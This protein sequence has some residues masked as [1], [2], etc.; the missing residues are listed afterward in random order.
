V[1][2]GA[3]LVIYGL[4]VVSTVLHQQDTEAYRAGG[5][6][7]LEGRPLYAT[8]LQHPFPD[9]TLR[10][11]YI[12]PPAF[13]LLMVPLAVLPSSVAL[14]VWALVN[15]GALLA[16]A[17]LTIRALH[18]GR[19]ALAAMVAATATFYPLWI[20]A[21]QGQANLLILL[22]VC[23]GLVGLTQRQDRLAAAI[24]VAAALKLT[25]A[26]FLL[27]LLLE[28]RW[29]AAVWMAAAFLATTAAGAMV[30]FQDTL[31][32]FTRVLPALAHGTAYYANQSLGGFLARVGTANRY[33]DPWFLLP[34]VALMSLLG[35]LL[36]IAWYWRS[37][38]ADPRSRMLMFLPLLPLL[39][40]VT[41]PHHLVIL[42]PLLWG[43]FAALGA[44]H[45]PRLETGS[46]IAIL[47]VF[48]VLSRLPLGPSF[49]QAGFR[50]AQTADPLVLLTANA[51]LLGTL[52]LF[53]ASPWL[54][55]SR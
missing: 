39:S 23:L 50:T 28:R 5:E 48:T 42:L 20:D 29:R 51:F 49:G 15:Q 47:L 30:R 37:R 16:A 18:P 21:A 33:T 53:V 11:A 36:V 19:W 31:T 34:V 52:L 10:P 38:E 27:W 6:A 44:H 35:L 41:W 24:G 40:A 4:V 43:C 17:F 1:L 13:A 25:P 2:I 7:L 14:L 8:F 12:Y 54:L 46:L 22:L 45:W 3:S 32:F 26:L 9:P 55:R